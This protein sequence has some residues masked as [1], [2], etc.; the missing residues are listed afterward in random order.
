[1]EKL[2]RTMN[3]AL[4]KRMSM[5]RSSERIVVPVNFPNDH[6]ILV[7]ANMGKKNSVL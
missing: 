1:M 5:V 7:A 3:K 2:D 6:W 4:G